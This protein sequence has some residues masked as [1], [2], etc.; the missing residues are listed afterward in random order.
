MNTISV[1]YTYELTH[2]LPNKPQYQWSKCGRLFNTK[3]AREIKKT[4]GGGSIGYWIS[5]EFISVK[6][7]RKIVTKIKDSECPF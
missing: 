7:L 5:K 1:T 2:E 4:F 6:K 3:T